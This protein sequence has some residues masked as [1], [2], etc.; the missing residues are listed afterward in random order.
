MKFS[1]SLPAAVCISATLMTGC[2]GLA[3]R[4][5]NENNV[6][7]NNSAMNITRQSFGKLPDGQEVDLYT[8]TNQNGMKACITNFGGVVTRL[9]VPRKDG[10]ATD[11]VLGYDSLAPYLKDSPYFG[12]IVGR[13]GNRIAKGRFSLDGKKYE[14]ATNNGPN[15]LHGGIK[16]FD[17]VLWKATPI[18]Q[19]DLVGLL[20]EYLS[21][22][23]EEGYPGNLHVKVWY[24]LTNNNELQI[25]YQAETDKPTPVNI[26]HHS[27]FNL[28]G[29]GTGSI[30][31]HRLMI[32][33]DRFV[34]VD[35]ALIPT[36]L[37][38]EVENTPMDFRKPRAI[39]EKIKEIAG[40]YDHTWVLNNSNKM[41]LIAS[42]ENSEATLKM[43]VYTTE[44]GVQFYSGN[45][46]DGSIEGKN[47]LVYEKHYGLCLETQ[48]FPD[49]PNQPAFPGTILRPG[50]KYGY[51]TIY[52]FFS[53]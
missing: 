11:V 43:E 18:E 45:F 31:N 22:D 52:K 42:L 46:L 15:H 47:G 38:K 20:L 17:K 53:K 10:S 29:A 26:T 35:E 30:L 13:Y 21:P 32:D 50:Q 40:G 24:L 3:N 9:L 27:Y 1:Y 19:N 7:K 23:G 41:A 33:A 5:Q 44:P 34:E 6:N 49:S 36:G 12:A 51:T 8:L 48:H 4:N 39:G 37:L 2:L 28:D 16:G 25:D 14:L